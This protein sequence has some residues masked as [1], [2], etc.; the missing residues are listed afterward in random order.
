MRPQ[1]APAPLACPSILARRRCRAARSRRQASAAGRHPARF[2]AAA[3]RQGSSDGSPPSRLA[4][5]RR[6]HQGRRG[7]PPGRTC[8]PCPAACAASP[9]GSPPAA[10]GRRCPG[11]AGRTLAGHR[12]FR[13]Q[14]GGTAGPARPSGNRAR[15]TCRGRCT[16]GFHRRRRSLP[17]GAATQGRLASPPRGAR[18]GRARRGGWWASRARWP[19][20]AGPCGPCGQC[21]GRTS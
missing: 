18:R 14:S 20:P 15:Q 19:C 12:R 17:G 6:R 13:W 21:G 11:K 9:R 8:R 10:A 3:C 7:R 2:V 16:R 1:T 5:R 4:R